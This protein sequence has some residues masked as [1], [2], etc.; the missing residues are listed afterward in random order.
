MNITD[1]ARDFILQVLS[2]QKANNIRVI[3]AGYG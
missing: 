1:T 3:W 2:E